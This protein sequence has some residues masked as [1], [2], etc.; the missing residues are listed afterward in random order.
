MCGERGP[1]TCVDPAAP[2]VDDDDVIADMLENCRYT[3][4]IG[5]GFCDWGNNKPEC[6]KSSIFGIRINETQ[7]WLH[8]INIYMSKASMNDVFIKQLG[9]YP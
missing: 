7:Q 3:E 8:I 6:C 4:R 5:D 9:M 1:F 2:C